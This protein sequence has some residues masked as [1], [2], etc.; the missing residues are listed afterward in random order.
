MRRYCDRGWPVA[1]RPRQSFAA[2]F[3]SSTARCSGLS[4]V[5]GCWWRRLE[6]AVLKV[7][8]HAPMALT[9]LPPSSAVQRIRPGYPLVTASHTRTHATMPHTHP[10]TASNRSRLIAT[11]LNRHAI[12]PENQQMAVMTTHAKN[13]QPKW[14]PAQKN[15]LMTRVELQLSDFPPQAPDHLPARWPGMALEAPARR[16]CPAKSGR[17]S[18]RGQRCRR[19]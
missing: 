7:V 19:V 3:A 4:R 11:C 8:L 5:A 10:A 12:S 18:G 9:Q 17:F 1:V 13:P 2:R 15:W 16:Y 14:P 6:V